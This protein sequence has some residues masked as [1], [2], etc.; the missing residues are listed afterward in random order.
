MQAMDSPSDH[1]GDALAVPRASRPRAVRSSPGQR[2]P[3][4]RDRGRHRGRSTSGAT[5]AGATQDASKTEGTTRRSYALVLTVNRPAGQLAVKRHVTRAAQCG[6]ANIAVAGIGQRRTGLRW[7][8]PT[9]RRVR[10]RHALVVG[11]PCRR[12]SAGLWREGLAGGAVVAAI[13]GLFLA[14]FDLTEIAKRYPCRPADASRRVRPCPESALAQFIHRSSF[15]RDDH[16]N[17]L[18]QRYR[19]LW[20]PHPMGGRC[21]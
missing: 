17:L 7:V 9:T 3:A 12:P 18:R 1:A 11:E 2:R 10:P 20:A 13:G 16:V 4:G 21:V 6:R 19:D 15:R 14:A 5:S 8:G